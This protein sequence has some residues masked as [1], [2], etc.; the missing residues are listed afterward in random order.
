MYVFYLPSQMKPIYL[1]SV[2]SLKMAF[3]LNNLLYTEENFFYNLISL[4]AFNSLQDIMPYPHTSP[5]KLIN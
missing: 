1:C 5:V 4:L 2:M 3:S